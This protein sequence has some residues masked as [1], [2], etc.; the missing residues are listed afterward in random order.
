MVTA[1]FFYSFMMINFPSGSVDVSVIRSARR[2]LQISVQTDGQVVFR[3]PV[4]ITNERIEQCLHQKAAWIERVRAKILARSLTRV[5]P[6][7]RDG[8]VFFFLGEK[9]ILSISHGVLAWP[10]FEATPLGWDLVVPES[11]D[12]AAVAAQ[13]QR[14]LECWYRRKAETYLSERLA[15]WADH[16]GG[17]MPRL[18]LRVQQR[19]WGS[20]NSHRCAVN[21]NRKLVAFPMDVID[22]VVIHELCHL[23]HPDHSSRFWREVGAWCPLWRQHRQWLKSDALRYVSPL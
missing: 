7:Y 16:M 4:M 5:S 23:R 1:S 18:T 3:A 14:S 9:K 19:L 11:W 13:A 12:D 17:V 21:L 6:Q 2:T 8:G 20:C 22:Y 15:F 10:R